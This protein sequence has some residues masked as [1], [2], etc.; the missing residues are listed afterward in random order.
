MSKKIIITSD[1]TCDLNPEYIQ[2]NDIRILPLGINL[3]DKSYF[4]GVD[5]NSEMVFD[6]VKETKI[7]P[8]TA[9]TGI[10]GYLNF[11]KEEV[12][13]GNVVIHV[14]IGSKFSSCNN[15]ARLAAEEIG[16]D[17]YVI[18]SANLSTGQGLVVCE[19]VDRVKAGLDAETIVA[20]INEIIPKVD[21]SF[22][23]N[24]LDYMVKGGR[25]S[26]VT[27]LGANLLK[28]KPCIEVKDGAMGVGK[29]YRGNLLDV[30]KKYADEKLD[31]TPDQYCH[32]RVF[33]T[34]TYYEGFELGEQIAEYVKSKG[35]FDEVIQT[36]AGCT[37]SSHCGPDTLG[38]LF[39]RK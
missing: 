28:L 36:R 24:R 26:S 22:I 38:V 9:A 2:E 4:D 12:D 19:I 11:F 33:V 21:A 6:Y 13:K 10:D 8:K 31:M 37:V 30:L 7:L 25:C 14:N 1:S 23:L 20:E 35:M 32:K 17:V 15:S 18:D 29:K 34:Y 39:I 3:G 16:H 27:A 5:V